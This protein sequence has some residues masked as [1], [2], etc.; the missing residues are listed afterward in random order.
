MTRALVLLVAFSIGCSHP[1]TTAVP[2][3]AL[4]WTPFYWVRASTETASFEHASILYRTSIGGR[5]PSLVQLDLASSG[6]L[7]SGLPE[8]LGTVHQARPV[9][10]LYGLLGERGRL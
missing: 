7:T 2:A 3:V 1:Q 4:D 10:Q 8:P 5:K 9:G 6:Q